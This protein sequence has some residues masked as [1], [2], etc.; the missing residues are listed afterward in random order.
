MPGAEEGQGGAVVGVPLLQGGGE[1]EADGGVEVL[2]A[3]AQVGQPGVQPGVQGH[4]LTA[5]LPRLHRSSQLQMN[6]QPQHSRER[7]MYA[8]RRGL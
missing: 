4:P 2:H 1:L 7:R 8:A 5:R 3:G 6:N